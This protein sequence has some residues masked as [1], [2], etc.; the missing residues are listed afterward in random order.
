MHRII[1][2]PGQPYIAD[3]AW[4]LPVFIVVLIAAGAIVGLLTGVITPDVIGPDGLSG[5]MMTVP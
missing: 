3:F 1:G 4:L 5:S 2:H